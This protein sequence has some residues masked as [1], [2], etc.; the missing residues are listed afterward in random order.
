MEN[1]NLLHQGILDV[2]SG[3]NKRMEARFHLYQDCLLLTGTT[4]ESEEPLFAATSL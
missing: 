3:K 2:K 1:R 4:D